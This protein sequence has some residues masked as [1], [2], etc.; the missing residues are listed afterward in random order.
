MGCV[1]AETDEVPASWVSPMQQQDVAC[2]LRIRCIRCIRCTYQV[3]SGNEKNGTRSKDNENSI[4]TYTEVESR[5][6]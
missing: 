6:E 1:G 4:H 2:I 3:E 5:V